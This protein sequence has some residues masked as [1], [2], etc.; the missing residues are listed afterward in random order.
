MNIEDIITATER[1]YQLEEE[2]EEEGGL[3]FEE[4]GLSQEGMDDNEESGDSESPGSEPNEYV[5]AADGIQYGTVTDLLSFVNRVSNM[6]SAAL[7]HSSEEV[8]VL[9]NKVRIPKTALLKAF[10]V[11]WSAQPNEL[12]GDGVCVVGILMQKRM[13]KLFIVISKIL[14]VGRSTWSWKMADTR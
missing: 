12:R 4:E 10:T 3:S 7:K 2:Q 8:G 13:M 5:K 14:C 1:L 9:L 6:Q 11:T